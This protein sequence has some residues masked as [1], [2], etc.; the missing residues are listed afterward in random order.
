[1]PES[2]RYADSAA[3]YGVLLGRYNTV[4]DEL[5][6]GQEVYLVTC[7]WSDRP[8]PGARPA[9]HIEWH[10]GAE[11]WTSVCADP[12]EDDPYYTH[13]FV[14][15]ISWRIGVIDDLLRAVA[16]DATAGVMVADSEL[17]R[18]H[19]PYDGGADVLL[20]TRAER[21]LLRNRH[22]DWLSSHPEG[23]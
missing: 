12:A 3:E 7:D 13:L 23:L 5:F 21:D 17:R 11:H 10:P 1:M 6:T 4:L 2:K 14:S 22:A 9:E 15:R 19:H 8:E 20:P 16:D 18:I